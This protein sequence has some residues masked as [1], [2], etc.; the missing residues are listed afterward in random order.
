MINPAVRSELA[1]F[2]APPGG[3]EVLRYS[4]FSRKFIP[5]TTPNVWPSEVQFFSDQ[6]GVGGATARDTNMTKGSAIGNPR[7]FLAQFLNFNIYC[8]LPAQAI[9]G[10][11]VAEA[12]EIL[13]QTT[14]RIDVLDKEYLTVPAW[15]V[16]AGGGTLWTGGGTL[17][18]GTFTNGSPDKRNAYPI[19]LNLE[20]EASFS[21]RLLS[22]VVPAAGVYIGVTTLGYYVECVLTGLL[23]R[24]GQ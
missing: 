24:P 3:A 20:R 19:E 21:V 17:A 2:I 23:L 14:I 22:P 4:Y 11:A 8:A 5:A 6:N 12:N 7:R 10:T 13:M 16:P 1:A 15:T 9:L 18:N